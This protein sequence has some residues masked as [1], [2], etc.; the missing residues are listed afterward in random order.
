M[1]RLLD[2]CGGQ[3]ILDALKNEAVRS[4]GGARGEQEAIII[5]TSLAIPYCLSTQARRARNIVAAL[6]RGAGRISDTYV[7]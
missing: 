6:G 2:E 5:S 1:L 3:G 4:S 7:C